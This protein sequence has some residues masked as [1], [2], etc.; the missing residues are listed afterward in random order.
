MK[1][2]RPKLQPSVYSESQLRRFLNCIA[3]PGFTDAQ[4]AATAPLPKPT[5]RTLSLLQ[6]H[7][8]TT[9][10]F[11]S[12]AINYEP[13]GQ[14]D[15]SPAYV[16][17]RFVEQGC[18]GYCFQANFLYQQMLRAVGYRTFAVL[19]RVFGPENQQYSGLTHMA[20]LVYLPSHLA[21]D[22]AK[23]VYYLADIGYGSN[24]QRPMLLRH[25]HVEPGRGGDLF[26][27]L[28]EPL[29]PRSCFEE[30][31]EEED[32][33]NDQAAASGQDQVA[34]QMPG[35]QAVWKLQSKTASRDTWQ[36]CY[37]LTTLEVFEPDCAASNK[38]VS[39]KTARPFASTIMI[40]KFF[41]DRE[42]L[43]QSDELVARDGLHP[44]LFPYHPSC[45]EQKMIV[46]DNK[47][48]TK[49]S[50][51][52]IVVHTLQTEEERIQTIKRV[53][54][55]LPNTS[56]QQALDEIKGKPSALKPPSQT[57]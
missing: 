4:E 32:D 35:N 23:S 53:F 7:C 10:P 45:I 56:L 46:G 22:N 16:F 52:Q 47:L 39:S 29:Q 40:V 11:E 31:D 27:L 38:A 20:N 36:E 13:G 43:A 15:L 2:M 55:L 30:V 21:E 19:G 24:V 3:F 6:A 25:G 57:A 1:A 41:W 12:L 51:D 33:N 28:H 54:G 50:T 14:M 9:F 48:I 34:Q 17:E 8:V 44:D 5:L 18:G 37:S 42:R 49:T 26:R